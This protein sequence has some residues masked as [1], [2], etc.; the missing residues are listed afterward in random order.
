MIAV[1][2]IEK[3]L[4]GQ[5]SSPPLVDLV[6]R[7]GRA[8]SCEGPWFFLENLGYPQY[9]S[10]G[11]RQDVSRATR[12]EMSDEQPVN[13]KSTWQPPTIR[14][15]GTIEKLVQGGGKNS[16]FVDADPQGGRKQ[17]QG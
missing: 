10:V 4:P 9:G 17:G 5:E 1:V 11:S 12:A 2:E 8:L 14:E 15:I 7:K 13:A 16:S 3:L 6:R